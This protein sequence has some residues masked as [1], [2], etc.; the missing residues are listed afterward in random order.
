MVSF[1]KLISCTSSSERV[2]RDVGCTFAFLSG[3]TMPLWALFL[4]DLMDKFSAADLSSPEEAWDGVKKIQSNYSLRRLSS[5]GFD[6]HILG[7]HAHLL[8]KGFKDY[9]S[10]VPQ[11]YF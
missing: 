4:G 3:I 10:Q 11:G 6:W 1:G 7:L 2:Y 8:R 5:L 9:Q